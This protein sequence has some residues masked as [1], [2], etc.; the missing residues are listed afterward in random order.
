MFNYYL[1]VCLMVLLI[2]FFIF[3]KIEYIYIYIIYIILWLYNN[4]IFDN[5]SSPYNYSNFDAIQTQKKIY[6]KYVLLKKIIGMYFINDIASL[7]ITY[8]F[9]EQKCNYVGCHHIVITMTRLQPTLC[10]N[11]LLK[12]KYQERIELL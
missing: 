9:E 11:H 7:I 5:M 4:T 1:N 3:K 12:D 6:C 8:M 10:S 2:K